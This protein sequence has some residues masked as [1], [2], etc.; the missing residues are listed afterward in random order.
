MHLYLATG[1]EPIAGYAGPVADERLRLERVPWREAVAA[2]A[3]GRIEDAKSL[4]G[5][6]WLERLA[7]R[8]ELP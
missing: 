4:V 2:A 3:D 8:G 7:E 6:L 5:L 1:L